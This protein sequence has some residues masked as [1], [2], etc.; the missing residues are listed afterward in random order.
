MGDR[1]LLLSSSRLHR[2]VVETALKRLLCAFWLCPALLVS[3]SQVAAQVPLS[4]LYDRLWTARDGAPPNI[5][6]LALGPDGLIWIGTDAGLFR[7]DGVTFSRYMPPHG[8]A[9]LSESIFSVTVT[10]DGSAWITYSL[11]GLTRISKSKITNFTTRE[12]L[13]DHLIYAASND[14]QGRTWI[15]GA[16]GLQMIDGSSVHI[17]GSEYVNVPTSATNLTSDRA[18]D[19]WVAGKGGISVLPK[20]GHRFFQADVASGY[21]P[22]SCTAARLVGV[23]CQLQS[24]LIAHYEF[25]QEAIRKNV[26]GKVA[27][28][29]SVMESQD[30]NLWIN[31]ENNGLFHLSAGTKH[32]FDVALTPYIRRGVQTKMI[33]DK[34]GSLWVSTTNGLEQIRHVPF[35]DR[36]FDSFVVLPKGKI[37][38][39]STLIGSSCLYDISSSIRCLLGPIP[40]DIVSLYR[41][42][43]GTLWTG[44]YKLWRYTGRRF[45]EL[46]LPGDATKITAIRAISEDDRNRIW[47]AVGG[48][49]V[50]LCREG[51][52][53]LVNGGLT[54]FPN[55]AVFSM[56]RDSAGALWFGYVHGRAVRL[57]ADQLT[58]YGTGDGLDL[59]AIEVF[60]N[61]GGILWVGGEKGVAFWNKGRFF[62]IQLA[63]GGSARNITGMAFVSDGSLWING[64]SGVTRIAQDQLDTLKVDPTHPVEFRSFDSEDGLQAVSNPNGGSGSILLNLDGTLSIAN[65]THLNTVDPL[66]LPYNHLAPAVWVTRWKADQQSGDWPGEPIRTVAEV[67]S[68]EVD[69]TATSLLIPERVRFR[70]RLKGYDDQWI[71][72]GARRQAFYSKVPPG[73]YIFQVLACNDSGVWNNTGA[74]LTI[75]VPPTL[76]QTSTFKICC[77]VLSLGLL[78]LL[79]RL[80]VR[81]LTGRVKE[82][83]FERLSERERIAREL[84][85]TFFQNIQGLLLRFNTAT[86]ALPSDSP[87]R[88]VLEETLERSDRVMSEGREL[89]LDLRNAVARPDDLPAVLAEFGR[90]LK[91]DHSCEFKVIVNG[92]VQPLHA[93]VAKELSTIGR[94]AVYN[95]FK[96]AS[97]RTIEVEL[98]YERSQ[99]RMCI[100]DNGVGVESRV[101]E[102]GKREGHWGL[103]GMRERASKIGAALS[104]WSRPGAGTEVEVRLT[105]KIAFAGDASKS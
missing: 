6:D 21:I 51:T 101:L 67:R 92:A 15:G 81:Q 38:N 31:T 85:D 16:G 30:G 18:G 45:V 71:E 54:G 14:G 95:A 68:L 40:R 25:D 35:H 13:Q 82:R 4:Q 8:S 97:A 102:D 72:A 55:E 41:A 19:L 33:Q 3:T 89:V 79:Y 74:S 29:E 69:Y 12:G 28:T 47:I 83:L 44:G 23:W 1:L 11:G 27:S 17:V 96:H 52:R 24:G 10:S 48:Q 5:T 36:A 58:V 57:A 43:N 62:K 65:Q 42:Q 100:R 64:T 70:Y 32:A 86:A 66:H 37:D 75:L 22:P 39:A 104:I 46:G 73:T 93:A 88:R 56:Y 98:S 2:F 7:F 80:R 90:E 91:A 49:N 50:L 34:E 105:S 20:N 94:E 76:F 78:M 60:A 53:W 84:H 63:D 9:L 59:G 103:P 26:L 99:L 87:S 61:S 77:A